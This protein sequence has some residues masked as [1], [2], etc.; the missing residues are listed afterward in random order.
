VEV[1]AVVLAILAVHLLRVLQTLVVA[2]VLVD[3]Q[4][5][6]AQTVV[7]VLLFCATQIPKQLQLVQV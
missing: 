6:Q 1:V 3:N 5:T 7:Q 4:A 2:V